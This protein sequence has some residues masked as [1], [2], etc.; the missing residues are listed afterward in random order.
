[1]LCG[2]LEK[3]KDGLKALGLSGKINTAFIERINLTIRQG[4]AFL[5]CRTWGTAQFSPE[6]EISLEWWRGYDHFSRFHESLRVELA[7]PIQCQGKH[8]PRRCRSR[9]PAMAAGLTTHRWTVLEL[10][11]YPLPGVG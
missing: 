10:I 9:I 6:L 1:M 11:C 3:L 5:A 2:E 4:I 8:L 7:Q